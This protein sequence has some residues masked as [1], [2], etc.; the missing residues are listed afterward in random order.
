MSMMLIQIPPQVADLAYYLG[1]S[2]RRF[3]LADA[4]NPYRKFL[5]GIPSPADTDEMPAKA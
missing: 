5:N 3:N 4:Q 1:T 2:V